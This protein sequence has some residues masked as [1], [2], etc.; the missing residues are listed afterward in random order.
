MRRE[1]YEYEAVE[2]PHSKLNESL[3]VMAKDKWRYVDREVCGTAEFERVYSCI[4]EREKP[5][6]P[7][8]STTL[9][10]DPSPPLS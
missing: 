5:C 9:P 8:S 1:G 2:V 6:N 10:P 3:N 7:S 4:F